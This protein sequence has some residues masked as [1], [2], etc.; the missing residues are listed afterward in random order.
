MTRCTYCLEA[1]AADAF[2]KEGDHVI[3]A[4]LGGGW[5]DD[6]VCSACNELANR[7][8]DQLIAK[9]SLVHYLR[10]AYRVPNRY[11][12]PPSSCQFFVRVPQGGGVKVTLDEDG[13]TFEAGMPAAT[14]ASLEIRDP[15][16]QAVLG[17][18]VADQLSLEDAFA[19]EPL[20]LAQAAQEFA[21]AATP[22]ATWSR[23][24]AKLGLACGR[25]AYGDDWL[26]GRQASILSNDLRGEAFP[27]FSQREH[28]PPVKPVWPYEPPKHRL[29]IEPF[30]DTALLMIAL[31][32]QVIGS[33]PL[34]DLP[35][36]G[37]PS[38]WSLDPSD[39]SMYRSTFPAIW[40][41][42]ATARLTR[43]GH[44]VVTVAVDP[45]R[46]FIFAEDGPT[47][48]A[49][50]PIPTMRADSPTHALE[51]FMAGE[52]PDGS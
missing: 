36:E 33:V 5:V 51:L 35:A 48:P 32:G 49:E 37:D 10:D 46:S 27:K 9:D 52:R 15:T 1:K 50:M 4:S 29:W 43:E 11:G 44:N 19:L 7:N 2:G 31:F 28:Y 25:E 20:R 22:K 18:V 17:R 26:D 45:D 40:L 8:A 41:G 39:R 34:N 21:V 23:F 6:R 12:K 38:A 42:T 3:P 13:P 30:N 16:N 47:G 24:M 14:L